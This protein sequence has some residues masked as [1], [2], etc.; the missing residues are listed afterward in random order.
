MIWMRLVRAWLLAVIGMAVTGVV[1]QTQFV[2]GALADIGA[3]ISMAD[4]LSMTLA[5][6]AGFAPLYAIVIAIG[7]AIAFF[8]GWLLI[9][10]AGLPRTPVYGVAGAV[11]MGVM[12]VAME[13]V[14]FGVQ[15]IAGARTAAGFSAQ[16][17]LGAFWGW[18]F[19]ALTGARR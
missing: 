15:L 8:A 10:F 12:L 2:L 4:R 14:F 9:R 16:V 11:C 7:F 19:A 3:P 17:L 13:K 6:L 5:D 18:T 1:V